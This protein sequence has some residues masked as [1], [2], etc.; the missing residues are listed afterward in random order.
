[1]ELSKVKQQYETFPYPSASVL[2]LLAKPHKYSIIHASYEAGLSITHKKILSS[3]NKK[4]ALIGCGT[5]E[6]LV[7]S[8]SHPT[9]QILACDISQKTLNYSKIKTTLRGIKNVKYFNLDLN[10]FCQKNL[11]LIDYAHCYG[12][13]HHLPHPELGF[14]SLGACL[15]P[16][17][18]FARIMVYSKSARQRISD[19]RR[20]FQLLKIDFESKN[21][22]SKVYE[23]I[24]TLPIEHPLKIT[25]L[26]HPEIHSSQGLVDAFLHVQETSF[27]L[28]EL[29]EKLDKAG[30][31][32]HGWDFS[33]NTKNLIKDAIGS[34]LREKM[35]YLEATEQWP[36]H[37]TFWVAKHAP[38]QGVSGSH[39]TLNPQIGNKLPER[40]YSTLAKTNFVFNFKHQKLFKMAQNQKYLSRFELAAFAKEVQD[41]LETRIFLEIIS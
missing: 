12:V 23:F 38:I 34:N 37:F 9:A 6:P 28:K 27:Y 30:L 40:L 21:F 11:N 14:K 24:A 22:K 35:N 41:F 19:L 16:E 32:I 8:K 39:Y 13:L 29:E 5:Q 36:T 10:E 7:F 15:K 26:K 2:G 33:L 18:G 1:M 25:F 4:I 20:I 3:D 17:G 31:F